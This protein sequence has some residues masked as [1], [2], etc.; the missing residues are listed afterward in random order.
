MSLNEIIAQAIDCPMMDCKN[1]AD[2]I[3]GYC[4]YNIV[5][6]GEN[7]YVK[8][9]V[10][11]GGDYPDDTMYLFDGEYF[12]VLDFIQIVEFE[13]EQPG[14]WSSIRNPSGGFTKDKFN[15]H[16]HAIENPGKFLF[17]KSRCD[18][19]YLWKIVKR[20]N[21]VEAFREAYYRDVNKWSLVLDNNLLDDRMIEINYCGYYVYRSRD[22][23]EETIY[24]TDKKEGIYNLWDDWHFFRTF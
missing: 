16:K 13:K 22:D 11:G 14:T 18:S 1:V 15:P 6:E 19:I 3:A 4:Q 8:I 10:S 2:I 20:Y 9:E 23:E 21:T 5:E 12:Y 24:M 7:K 17:T